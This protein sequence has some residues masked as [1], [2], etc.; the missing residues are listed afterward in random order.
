M[1]M[2]MGDG[3]SSPKGGVALGGNLLQQ[4]LIG[5]GKLRK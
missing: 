2:W 5:I 3:A 4:L 1:R